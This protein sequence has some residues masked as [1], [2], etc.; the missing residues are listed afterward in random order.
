[1]CVL[2]AVST[3]QGTTPLHWAVAGCTEPLQGQ[4]GPS[5]DVLNLLVRHGADLHQLDCALLWKCG[6]GR[7]S[8]DVLLWFTVCAV[9]GRNALHIVAI[10]ANTANGRCMQNSIAV[11][12]RLLSLGLGV[13]CADDR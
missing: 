7:P 9:R 5:V 1:M 4:F 3:S 13:N 6:L 10:H 11:T 2:L 12:K 8:F